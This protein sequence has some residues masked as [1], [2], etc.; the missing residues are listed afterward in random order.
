[1]RAGLLIAFFLLASALQTPA[2][3]SLG[4]EKQSYLYEWTDGKGIV[5]LTDSLDK[6]PKPYR[7]HA[8]RLET[9]PGEEAAPNQP[10]QQGASSPAGNAEDQRET[11]QKAF[12]QQR[13]NAAKQRLAAAQ[14]HYRELEQ[15]QTTL[16]G[17]WGTPAYAPPE[18]RIEAERI[19]QEMQS[20]QKEIDD[21]R[22]DVEVAIPEEARKAGVPPGWLRE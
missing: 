18:A 11:Q 13:V 14:Q 4:D 7:P 10:Q 9:A 19:A 21:A 22:N 2:Q 3:T 12:W 20:V 17:Q 15:R 8:R 16:L 6:V 5:H 1:M